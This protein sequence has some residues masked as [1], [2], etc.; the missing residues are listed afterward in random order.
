M[1]RPASLGIS[2]ALML[3]AAA[4]APSSGPARAPLPFI[5]PDVTLHDARLGGIGLLGGTIDLEMTVYNPNAY[6]LESPRVRF[7]VLLGH[8]EIAA[9]T[10]DL[11]VVVPPYDSTIVRLPASFA[12]AGLSRAGREFVA[13]GAATYRVMGRIA[14]GTPDGR[15]WFPYERVGR[16]SM[17]TAQAR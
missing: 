3:L 12:Y 5:R 15:L 17:L 6:A 14:V 2:L 7:H 9:G 1:R 8:D 4:C 13:T 16:I 10:A 11:D